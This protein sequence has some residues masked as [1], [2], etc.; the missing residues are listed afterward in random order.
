MWNGTEFV[1]FE[2]TA[3]IGNVPYYYT[4]PNDQNYAILV[5]LDENGQNKKE[6]RLPL[7]EGL[8]QI[9]IVGNKELKVYYSIA[10]SDKTL[11]AWK[12][13]KGA[14]AKGSYMIT[15]SDDSLMVQVTPNN[16]D[17][18]KTE[19]QLVNS[20]NE[21]APVTLGTPI[22]YNG[23]YTRAVSANGL[24][25]I[26]FSIET[27]TDEIVEAYPAAIT[28]KSPALALVAMIRFVLYMKMH[29][30]LKKLLIRFSLATST[31]VRKTLMEVLAFLTILN[32]VSPRL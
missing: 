13:P 18:A 16:F 31:L 20:K 24:F 29:W 19:L 15:Y 32:Q 8:A 5:V 12:G 14:P 23:L 25:Q 27:I 17:L 3:T 28:G 1:E 10:T 4:D 22:A 11:Q 7:N 26:P 21:V 6:I 9:S 2:G 30:L